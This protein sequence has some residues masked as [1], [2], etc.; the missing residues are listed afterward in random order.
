MKQR[1]TKLLAVL[2]FSTAAF[3]VNAQ[4]WLLNGNAGTNGNTNFIGTTDSRPL[5]FRTNNRERMRII[6]GGKIGIGTTVPDARFNVAV[7]S[8]V[9]LTTTD[10]FLLGKISGA[11]LAFDNNEIQCRNNG[12]GNTLYLNYWGGAAWIGN[13]NG[14]A[15]PGVYINTDGA[16]G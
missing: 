11:N 2:F 9:T 4:N 1:N 16:A 14:S 5:V 15:I 3:S 10:S 8:G 12:S 6:T 7:G 13:H